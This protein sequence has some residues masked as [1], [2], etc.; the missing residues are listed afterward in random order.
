TFPFL[1]RMSTC[2]EKR[3]WLLRSNKQVNKYFMYYYNWLCVCANVENYGGIVIA[4][5]IP[6]YC[7]LCRPIKDYAE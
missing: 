1:I 6:H 2:W 4:L 5:K 3:R 7:Y